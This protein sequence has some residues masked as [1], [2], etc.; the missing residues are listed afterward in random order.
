[1]SEV[2]LSTFK[3]NGKEFFRESALETVTLKTVLESFDQVE[4]LVPREKRKAT[5][6][7]A[8]R[9]RLKLIVFSRIVH[10]LSLMDG[11]NANCMKSEKPD[12]VPGR[13]RGQK[14]ASVRLY[15]PG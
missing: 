13:G 10:C 7:S 11:G 6:V 5:K 14:E 2:V 1:M 4:P 3:M 9:N 8:G 15:R 12:Q